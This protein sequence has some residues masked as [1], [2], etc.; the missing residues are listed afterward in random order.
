MLLLTLWALVLTVA[1][2]F[3]VAIFINIVYVA[4][5]IYRKLKIEITF[6]AYCN[7]E[8]QRCSGD[9]FSLSVTLYSDCTL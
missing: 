8:L 4:T 1:L 9:S 7:Q 6:Q 3:T 2:H 5:G